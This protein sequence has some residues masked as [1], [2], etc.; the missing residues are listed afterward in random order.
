MFEVKKKFKVFFAIFNFSIANGIIGNCNF[1]AIYYKIRKSSRKDQNF[2][3]FK[4]IIKKNHFS[5]IYF[6]NS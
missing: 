3:V 2:E 4:K 1:F 5:V 6:K